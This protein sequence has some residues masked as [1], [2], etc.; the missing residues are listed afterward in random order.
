MDHYK[1]YKWC[2]E[3]PVSAVRLCRMKVRLSEALD[4]IGSLH[5]FISYLLKVECGNLELQISWL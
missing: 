2:E 3:P 1:G 5:L 4:T